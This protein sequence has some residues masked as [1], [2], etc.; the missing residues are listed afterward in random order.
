MIT[1]NFYMVKTKLKVGEGKICGVIESYGGFRPTCLRRGAFE[2][3][4]RDCVT[5]SEAAGVGRGGVFN[6]T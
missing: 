3:L 5:A 1:F 6:V 4:R 2:Q